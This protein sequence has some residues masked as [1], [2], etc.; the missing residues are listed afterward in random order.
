MLKGK[1][2]GT[3]TGTKFECAS[4]LAVTFRARFH[5]PVI[6]VDSTPGLSQLDQVPRPRALPEISLQRTHVSRAS[7]LSQELFIGHFTK[8]FAQLVEVELHVRGEVG[9]VVH[10]SGLYNADFPETL[11]RREMEQRCK[12]E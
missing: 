6:L 9:H 8:A 12:H 1:V 4:L 11:S 2:D 3:K 7:T 10:E 5:L